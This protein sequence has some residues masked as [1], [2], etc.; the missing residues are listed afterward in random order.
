MDLKSVDKMGM[1]MA[2]TMVLLME[3]MMAEKMVLMMV[4]G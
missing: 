2:V 4:E 3:M 1:M